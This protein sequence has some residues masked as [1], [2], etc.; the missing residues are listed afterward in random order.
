MIFVPFIAI[1]TGI[2][3]FIALILPTSTGFD[4][5]QFLTLRH[6]AGMMFWFNTFFPITELFT[7]LVFYIYFLAFMLIMY[8]ILYV[9]KVIRGN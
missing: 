9:V 4:Y 3:N 8:L 5:T 1:L 2:F 6:I 7:L